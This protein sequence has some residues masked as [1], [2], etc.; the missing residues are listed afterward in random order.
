MAY[1]PNFYYIPFKK[2][3]TSTYIYRGKRRNSMIYVTIYRFHLQRKM[4]NRDLKHNLQSP[5]GLSKRSYFLMWFFESFPT[6]S[7]FSRLHFNP[8]FII[9]ITFLYKLKNFNLF[10]RH[11]PAFTLDTTSYI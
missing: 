1:F 4:R 6:Q 5:F 8:Y 11:G 3:I 7:I 2:W 9:L 10:I